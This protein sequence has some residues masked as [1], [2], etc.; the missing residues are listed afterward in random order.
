MR[1]YAGKIRH[2]WPLILRNVFT[3]LSRFNPMAR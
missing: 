1:V 3:L 2:G